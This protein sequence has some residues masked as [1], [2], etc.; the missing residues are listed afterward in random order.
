[1]RQCSNAPF[2]VDRRAIL[3]SASS[4]EAEYGTI[5]MSPLGPTVEAFCFLPVPK[6]QNMEL[7]YIN[8]PFTADL[9]DILLSLSS[10]EAEYGTKSMSPLW[11]TLEAICFL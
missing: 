3:F 5:P 10:K 8:L 9:R 2:T 1:M 7:L 11:L 6:K 4:K